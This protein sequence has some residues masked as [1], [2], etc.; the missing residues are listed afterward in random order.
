MGFDIHIQNDRRVVFV[1]NGEFRVLEHGLAVPVQQA[2]IAFRHDRVLS[3][4]VL[5]HRKVA[6]I[7][8]ENT[9]DPILDRPVDAHDFQMVR[10]R[11]FDFLFGNQLLGLVSLPA[12]EFRLMAAGIHIDR[13]A[14][15]A[16]FGIGKAEQQSGRPRIAPV[17]K[18]GFV[19]KVLSFHLRNEERVAFSCGVR[20]KSIIA[21]RPASALRDR[22]TQIVIP[23]IIRLDWLLFLF[24]CAIREP[25]IRERRLG[26]KCQQSDIAAFPVF[27]RPGRC[28]HIRTHVAKC[29]CQRTVCFHVHRQMQWFGRIDIVDTSARKNVASRAE[30]AEIVRL[31]FPPCIDVR[32]IPLC[33]RLFFIGRAKH[34]RRRHLV[35]F[36]AFASSCQQLHIRLEMEIIR[37]GFLR[38]QHREMIASRVQDQRVLIHRASPRADIVEV[39]R[40]HIVRAFQSGFRVVQ[41]LQRLGHRFLARRVV[42]CD[43]FGLVQVGLVHTWL[44][45]LFL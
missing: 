4:I 23:P 42:I 25:D 8:D 12:P 6:K 36:L 39:F 18:I 5:L 19:H 10:I 2:V 3:K 13:V 15:L 17:R 11:F 34:E 20:K 27:D 16:V 14:F 35:A 38:A 1:K 7:G 30:Y 41:R 22:F 40:L 33:A 32:S 28:V 43:F 31:V 26:A 9:V 21:H 45:R 44:D 29:I 24:D 37:R